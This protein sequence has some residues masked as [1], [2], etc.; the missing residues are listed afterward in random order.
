MQLLYV[1]L[2]MLSKHISIHCNFAEII[3][4]CY[5][6][7]TCYSIICADILTQVLEQFVADGGHDTLTV[8][9]CKSLL[10]G[11]PSPVASNGAS[12]DEVSPPTFEGGLAILSGYPEYP[13][14]HRVS[15]SLTYW[16]ATG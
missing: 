1:E 11:A 15:D 6:F 16:M 12:P 8:E 7:E 10:S 9:V 4:V 2:G 5:Y 13:L 14:Y 3:T